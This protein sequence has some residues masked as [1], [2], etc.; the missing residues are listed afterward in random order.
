MQ[1]LHLDVG[2][3]SA[4]QVERLHVLGKVHPA[5]LHQRKPVQ[6]R[7]LGTLGSGLGLGPPGCGGRARR[8]R[9]GVALGGASLRLD[10]YRRVEENHR[11]VPSGRGKGQERIL[12][13]RVVSGQR[14]ARGGVGVRGHVQLPRGSHS[15]NVDAREGV[16]CAEDG[17]PRRAAGVVVAVGGGGGCVGEALERAACNLHD[18]WMYGSLTQGDGGMNRSI[19]GAEQAKARPTHTIS[20]SPSKLASLALPET[21]DTSAESTSNPFEKA[22]RL[23]E[24]LGTRLRHQLSRLA[25]NCSTNNQRPR[26]LRE[27]TIRLDVIRIR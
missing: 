13:G 25:G 1:V 27:P 15:V 16:V 2:E 14:R 10:V 20:S 19:G 24:W 26:P 5:R 9:E 22:I 12:R 11:G 23:R 6:Q 4:H 21:V 8:A 18:W 3:S 7:A 17:H